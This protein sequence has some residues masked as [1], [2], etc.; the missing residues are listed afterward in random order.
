[1]WIRTNDVMCRVDDFSKFYIDMNS[2]SY[3]VIGKESDNRATVFMNYST[4][5]SAKAALDGLYEA[6]E[7]GDRTFT[8]RN[9]AY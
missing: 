7:R 3:S 4:Y 9:T 5:A 2:G 8:M 1:M 6:L